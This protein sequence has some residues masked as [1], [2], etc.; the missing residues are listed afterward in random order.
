MDNILRVL[1]IVLIWVTAIVKL[2]EEKGWYNI[3]FTAIT[4]SC[5]SGFIGGL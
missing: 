3:V 5:L 4:A 1:L 2:K